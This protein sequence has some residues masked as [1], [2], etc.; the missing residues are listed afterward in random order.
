METKAHELTAVWKAKD[1][2][3][4]GVLS[5]LREIAD[6]FELDIPELSFLLPLETEARSDVSTTVAFLKEAADSMQLLCA[7]AIS[8]ITEDNSRSIATIETDDVRFSLAAFQKISIGI[9]QQMNCLLS[10]V[11]AL[12]SVGASEESYGWQAKQNVEKKSSHDL[13][14][15]RIE[16]ME[17]DWRQAISSL[18]EQP[19]IL[20]S[21]I[22][23]SIIPSS[24]G[25][26]AHRIRLSAFTL[27]VQTISLV[28]REFLESSWE[29]LKSMLIE[30]GVDAEDNELLACL[31]DLHHH[32]TRKTLSWEDALDKNLKRIFLQDMNKALTK[33]E[34]EH[35]IS[36]FKKVFDN[37]EK[38]KKIDTALRAL[39]N[40]QTK[41][42]KSAFTPSQIRRQME[43][44]FGLGNRQ[45]RP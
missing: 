1:Y 42:K 30:Y 19:V 28:S 4:I 6:V 33:D 22:G 45:K 15:E 35:I 9:L 18:L 36:H 2:S 43:A 24:Q 27:E 13:M 21:L 29:K 11:S 37:M 12:R 31:A 23:A 5:G 14:I 3:L 20:K 44:D 8:I 7:I 40:A 10:W 16:E 32:R 25:E 26:A 17:R 34:Q 38:L 41:G 39:R